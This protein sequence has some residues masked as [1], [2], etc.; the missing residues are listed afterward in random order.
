MSRGRDVLLDPI[1]DNNP[2]ALQILGAGGCA[3]LALTLPW[4]SV[5][6]GIAVIA[7]GVIARAVRLRISRAS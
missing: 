2:I 6:G 3:V 4:Q 1:F 7:V 5:V